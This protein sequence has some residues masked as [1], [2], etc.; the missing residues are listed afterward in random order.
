MEVTKAIFIF[1]STIVFYFL[2]IPITNNLFIFISQSKLLI[3]SFVPF[4]EFVFL[5]FKVKDPSYLFPTEED[6]FILMIFIL[7]FV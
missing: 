4:L 2:T 3:Y 5:V 1:V 6:S 7:V